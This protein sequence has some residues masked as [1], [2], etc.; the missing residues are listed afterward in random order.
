[1]IKTV[2]LALGLLMP[3]TVF[4]VEVDVHGLLDFRFSS[5]DSI[6]S[7]LSA[8]MGKFGYSDGQQLS[9]AQLGADLS[10][11][12]DSG[13]SSHLV[14][15][16]YLDDED[17]AVGMTEAY[18][19]YRS[20]PN[21]SGY[22]WQSK[23]GIF[24]PE[25]S[26]ENNAFAWASKNTLA[27]STINTWIGEE[28]RVLGTEFKI[29]RLGK[30]HK[31]NN[32]FSF[33]GTVFTNNDP[34]GAMLSWHGWTLSSRQTLWTESRPI[35]DFDARMPGYDLNGQAG[36]SD[37]FLELD[38]RIGFHLKASWKLKGKGRLSSGYYDNNGIPYVVENGQYA[39]RTRF[40]HVDFKW[41]LP[42]ELELTA[43]YLH[44][45]TLMQSRAKVDV[46]NN[47]YASGY[48]ALSK[49]WRQHQFTV[50][51]EEFS[52]TD[53][54][55]TYGDDNTEYGKALTVNYRYRYAKFWFFSLEFNWIDSYRPARQDIAQPINLT[56]R[57]LQ[58]SLRY[59]F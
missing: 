14:V 46:V 28:I 41:R 33:S 11:S 22:R 49:K 38:D 31:S 32:D 30:M 36:K 9:L 50:R 24:Y 58:F 42:Y 6:D 47:D 8:G 57:Q 10:L 52:V 1:M 2:A 40:Y 3:V 27:S 20:L 19:K 18:L 37:P 12:W 23:L 43:Q 17:S 39:W 45:D 7:Y 56:E 48:L 4:A 35:P 16:G 59:F 13:I 54:D 53:N 21:Q 15:N 5:S 29:T 26:L 51:A 25:I 34:A 55:H 44:G